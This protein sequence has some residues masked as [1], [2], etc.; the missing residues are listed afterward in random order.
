MTDSF[1]WNIEVPP[2]FFRN[3]NFFVHYDVSHVFRSWSFMLCYIR[4]AT[5]SDFFYYWKNYAVQLSHEIYTTNSKYITLKEAPA[6]TTFIPISYPHCRWAMKR[7]SGHSLLIV[8]SQNF[9][10]HSLIILCQSQVV[11]N[12]CAVRTYMFEFDCFFG[13]LLFTKLI[14]L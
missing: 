2:L 14:Q 9:S 11:R 4:V 12:W 5:F 3:L 6:K 7:I 13:L 10:K 1:I 8:S